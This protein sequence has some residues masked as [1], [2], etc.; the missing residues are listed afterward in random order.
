[1]R[2]IEQR[3]QTILDRETTTLEGYHFVTR[4]DAIE[5]ALSLLDSAVS[6]RKKGIVYFDV[7]DTIFISEPILRLELNTYFTKKLQ[8]RGEVFTPV[9]FT[10][11]RDA[12]GR[13]YQVAA[14]QDAAKIIGEDFYEIYIR[15]AALNQKMHASMYPH[16]GAV[17]LQKTL[18][19]QGYCIGGYPTARPHELSQITAAGLKHFGFSKAPVID[20]IADNANPQHAKTAFFIEVIVPHIPEGTTVYFI[21]DHVKTAISVQQA[22]EGKVRSVVPIMARNRHEIP[23]LD[24]NNVVYGTLSELAWSVVR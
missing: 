13:Y 23:L 24:K 16:K 4:E 9:N 12:G 1:M 21:D 8:E 5:N 14:Y 10:Q 17:A 3:S 19:A 20:M 6:H 15:E 7:D 22:S 18:E 2:P 11:L